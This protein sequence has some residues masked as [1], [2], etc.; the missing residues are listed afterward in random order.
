M[1]TFVSTFRKLSFIVIISLI[2]Y[3]CNNDQEI[4]EEDN[5][6]QTELKTILESDDISAVADTVL[7]ELYMNNSATGKSAKNND[8]YS[9]EYTDAGF[10]ATFNNCVL[11]GTDNVNGTV[12][13]VYNVESETASYTATYTDFYV[14]TIKVNGT[15]TY[16]L[17][18]NSDENSISFSVTS[19]M[20]LEMEDGETVSE[21]GTK[22]F[23]VTFGDSLETSTLTIGGNWTLIVDG[24]TYK[25]NVT[26]TL[27]G[28]FSCAYLTTGI[29]VVDKNGLAVTVNFGDGTCDDL[30]TLIYPNG[31]EEEVSL[32]D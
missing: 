15:R 22:T 25:V 16:L 32:K 6:T 27:E 3:S 14:G 8:C 20:D 31:V 29:M 19:T 30:A 26:D 4:T 24:N 13:V 12:T 9:A 28:N 2:A 11:N 23:T 18:G 10:T 7:S 21:S 17:S 1:K 5:L